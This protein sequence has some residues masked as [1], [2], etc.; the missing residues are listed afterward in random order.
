MLVAALRGDPVLLAMLSA[1]SWPVPEYCE[2]QHRSSS[3]RGRH[4]FGMP[5]TEC[6]L[7]LRERRWGSCLT[8]QMAMS[9]HSDGSQVGHA[10]LE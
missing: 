5:C 7:R 3:Q 10:P 4:G 8:C 1:R 9:N 2:K 6:R